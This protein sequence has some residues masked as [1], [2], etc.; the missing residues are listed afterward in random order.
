MPN[1]DCRYLVIH[2][3][4]KD[5]YDINIFFYTVYH[6]SRYNFATNVLYCFCSDVNPY[7]FYVDLDPDFYL[8][9]DPDL[10]SPDADPD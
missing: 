9:T 3:C 7:L 8:T 6:F 4:V 1:Y 5:R 10:A 2:K